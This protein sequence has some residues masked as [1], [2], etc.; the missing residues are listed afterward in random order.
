LA[1]APGSSNV[2]HLFLAFPLMWPFPEDATSAAEH[3]RRVAA[4]VILAI[5]GLLTQWV[6]ISQFLVVSGPPEGQ[7]FP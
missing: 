5:C 3:R 6:W 1:T 2:R 7:P 4:V